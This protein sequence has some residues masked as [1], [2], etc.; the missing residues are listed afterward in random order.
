[1]SNGL[2]KIT[3]SGESG[4][5]DIRT[6][7]EG[8]VLYISLKDVMVTLNRENELLDDKH[9]PKSMLGIIRRQLDVLDEDEHVL[10]HEGGGQEVY[11]TQP[12]LYRV[13]SGD[14]SKAGKK[15]QKWLFHE[16]V[17]SIT[18]FGMYPP[19][20]ASKGSVLSQ[21]AELL[22]Q[23]SRALADTIVKQE[24]L[25]QDVNNVIEE[26]GNV[27]DRVERLEKSGS[28][29]SSLIT[30]RERLDFLGINF[31]KEKERE[32]IAWCEN[33]SFSKVRPHQSCP[34]GDRFGSRFSLQTIDEATALIKQS[35][36]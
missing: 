25:E 10:V 35:D 3:Y 30:V 20:A 34:S 33:I 24:Q 11:I 4:S 22:A 32:V 14:S 26:V 18:R 1:M 5:S 12:G 28:E 17:P 19:P 13:L 23:N 27:K 36:R 2:Q 31:T 9:I 16:V 21:M 15:F 7:V 6:F 8:D 29:Q